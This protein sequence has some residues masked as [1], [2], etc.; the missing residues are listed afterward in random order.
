MP[1]LEVNNLSKEYHGR[2]VVQDVSLKI[3][4]GEIV[5]LLGPNGAGKTTAFY[6]IMGLE[7]SDSGSIFFQKKPITRLPI[8]KRARL[9]MGYLAQEPSIFRQMSVRENL[10]VIL[11]T[12]GISKAEQK[13][14][15]ESL[16]EEFR[17][18]HLKDKPSVTLSGGERR[19]LEIA[20]T[21][22]QNPSL[23]LLDEPF[24][25]ID[26]VTIDELKEL[27]LKLAEKNISF[28]ITDHNVREIFKIANRCYL[29]QKG[30]VTHEGTPE[31][32]MQNNDV[33]YSYL[34]SSFRL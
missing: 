27:I 23:L 15:L 8:F 16:L 18:E 13:I 11:Q 3:E 17:L 21:L 34:G 19:R 1:L 6:M 20:R 31:Q 12:L 2:L 33:V 30:V 28:L 22:I 5:G 10:E 29:V 24:A 4:P 14:K 32:L 9:G 26:P 25:A 7:K